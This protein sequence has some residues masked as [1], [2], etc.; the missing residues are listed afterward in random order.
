MRITD[1]NMPDVMFYA[2][3]A[4][5]IFFGALPWLF[6]FR[7][8]RDREKGL[9]EICQEIAFEDFA[10]LIDAVRVF[11]VAGVV[12]IEGAT[13]IA[14]LIIDP[15]GYGMPSVLYR[16]ELASWGTLVIAATIIMLVLKRLSWR[17]AN[18]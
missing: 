14:W 8:L 4:L 5:M 15:Q 13:F 17:Y 9:D 12:G 7:S 2:S 18:Y 16:V 10:R 11:G 3:I 1:F 6:G